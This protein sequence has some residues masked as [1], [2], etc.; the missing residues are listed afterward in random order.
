M[1]LAINSSS[2]PASRCLWHPQSHVFFGVL[3]YP[4]SAEVC[5]SLG[6]IRTM[7]VSLFPSPVLRQ[8]VPARRQVSRWWSGPQS[9]REAG[10]D[11]AL[12]RVVH[13]A[14]N[15]RRVLLSDREV[16]STG[17]IVL[18]CTAIPLGGA[19]STSETGLRRSPLSPLLVIAWSG[20][21]HIWGRVSS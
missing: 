5:L 11:P 10:S 12:S 20:M 19:Y 21:H 17:H 8:S 13:V 3:R 9:R 1:T 15:Y 18:W 7:G 2:L 14:R 4:S 6:V 16:C